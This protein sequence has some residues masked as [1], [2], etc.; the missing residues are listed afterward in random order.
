MPDSNARQT[1]AFAAVGLSGVMSI[2][3]R[4]FPEQLKSIWF[5]RAYL[6]EM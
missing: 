4:D 6:L 2:L 3:W 1:S 5:R